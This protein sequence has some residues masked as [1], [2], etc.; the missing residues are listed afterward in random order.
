VAPIYFL[1]RDLLSVLRDRDGKITPQT[2]DNLSLL[3]DRFAPFVKGGKEKT[4]KTG[5]KALKD[6]LNDIKIPESLIENYRAFFDRYKKFLDSMEAK[7]G[8]LITTS[9]LVVGLGNESIYETSIRL[10]RNY[11]VPYIP[12]SAI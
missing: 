8:T 7:R 2:V 1:P 6:V 11:G 5:G 12:G 3:L 9:R 4:A 10:L